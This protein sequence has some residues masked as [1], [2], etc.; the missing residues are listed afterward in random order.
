MVA[1]PEDILVVVEGCRLQ[2]AVTAVTEGPGAADV[3]AG[4]GD[5]GGD[6]QARGLVSSE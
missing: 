1:H 5:G 2:R 3:E 6:P 4:L